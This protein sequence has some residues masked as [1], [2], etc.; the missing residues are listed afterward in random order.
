[1]DTI[2]SNHLQNEDFD[3]ILFIRHYKHNKLLYTRK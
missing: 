1:M 2:L 3:L